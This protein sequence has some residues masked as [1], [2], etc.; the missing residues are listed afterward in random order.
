MPT[1]STALEDQ[2]LVE[3]LETTRDRFVQLLKHLRGVF[4]TSSAL[5]IQ[6]EEIENSLM[7]LRS[8]LGRVVIHKPQRT[9]G[10]RSN[11]RP[12]REFSKTQ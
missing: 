6:A 4:G 1:G 11:G 10:S 2:T 12:M 7:S 8:A 3:Q 5:V 9:G